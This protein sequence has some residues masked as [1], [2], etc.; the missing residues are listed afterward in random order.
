VEGLDRP[1]AEALHLELRRLALSVGLSIR[2]FTVE[3]ID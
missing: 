3:R 2:R 1:A